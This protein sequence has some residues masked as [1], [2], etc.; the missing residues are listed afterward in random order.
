[1]YWMLSLFDSLAPPPPD[2]IIATRWGRRNL[3]RPR[4]STR[5]TRQCSR[6]QR[7]ATP[8]TTVRQSLS[9]CIMHSD[10][11]GHRHTW[12]VGVKGGLGVLSGAQIATKPSSKNFV[13]RH[14]PS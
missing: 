3:R 4:L 11:N 13:S 8:A 9:R 6:R 2:D 10:A 5:C 1:M 7:K 12:Q 14:S